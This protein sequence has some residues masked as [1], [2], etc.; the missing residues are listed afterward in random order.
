MIPRL[1]LARVLLDSWANGPGRRDVFWTAGCTIRCPGCVNP[2]FLPRDA[3]GVT[4]VDDLIRLLTVRVGR[5]E[6]ITLSGGEPLEQPEGVGALVDGARALGLTVVLLTGF[7]VEACLAD[8][9]RAALVA[10][11][12]LVVAGPFLRERRVRGYPLLAS[13]NQELIFPTGRYGPLDLAGIPAA[14]IL[15]S[16][17]EG[18]ITGIDA[19]EAMRSLKA[20]LGR[21]RW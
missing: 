16:P 6:G 10:G 1:R 17:D 19:G 8:P 4:P 9:R 14:E 15:I 3:G 21:T 2:E 7:T 20:S 13:D 11:C 18:I 12:D 5:V